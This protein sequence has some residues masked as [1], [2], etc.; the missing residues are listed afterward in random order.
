MNF[1]RFSTSDNQWHD[2]PYYVSKNGVWVEQNAV[3][4]RDSGKWIPASSWREFR[5]LVRSGDAPTLYPVG[6]K[7]YENWG[8]TT[9]DA[10][11]V[12]DYPT[13]E[14]Y[15][16]SDLA[17]QGYTN[18]VMLMEE[19]LNYLRVFDTKEAWLYV[20]TA[21]PAGTYRFTIPNYDASYGGNKTY[22]FTS[23]AN[24]P[25]G[26]QLTL[27]WVYNTNPTKVQGYSSSTSTSALFDV[28]ITEWDGATACTDLGT[29]KLAQ[30]D[31][32]ST[33]GKLNHIHRA[34]YGSNNYCQSGLRQWLNADATANWWM[35]S[36]I[37][38]R[39]YDNRNTAGRLN[40]LNSNMKAV[41]ATPAVNCITN[42]LFEC[43]SL[44]GTTF[45]L[46]TSYTVNDKLFLV[47]HT[48]TNLSSTPNVDSVLDYYTNAQNADRIKY[49][50][51]NENAY[52]WWL[53]TPY[54]PYAS[55]VR[56]VV[57]SGALNNVNANVTL[58]SAAAC[59]IQ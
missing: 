11:I 33:Y 2:V 16:D 57:T 30:N 22:I 37:F 44:D 24:V 42:N 8:D 9:S 19:K 46:Q 23:T 3:Y 28:N 48:E 50:K 13:G 26:G 29:I 12:V 1:K 51:V 58:G 10:W 36:N 31:T 53:R 32:D 27:T 54:P 20:E 43:P 7:L 25:V 49:R 59:I 6:T 17:Q 4:E 41:L 55:Y 40:T 18:R 35:P 5:D 15:L 39:P 38:D 21:I 52:Y 56:Y 47:T 34:R 14:D 45:S